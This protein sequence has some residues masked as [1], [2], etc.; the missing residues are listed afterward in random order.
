MKKG[1][2]SIVVINWNGRDDTVECVES[3]EKITRPEC[4]VIVV[5]NGSVDDSV[6]AL[7]E[8]F[9]ALLVLETGR[10]LGFAGGANFG[11]RRALNDGA[12]YVI[13]LNNDTVVDEGFA[14]EFVRAAEEHK[15]AG[16]LC[17]KVYF[18]DR[19]NTIWYA[20]AEFIT[21][22]G[23]GRHRGYNLKDDGRFDKLEETGRATGCSMMLTKE[24][25]EKAGLFDEEYFC[26]CEDMDLGMRAKKAGYKIFY[27]PA[28]RV[29]H[30]ESRAT[31]GLGSAVSL[32]YT[33]RNT[34]RCLDKNSPLPVLLRQVRFISIAGAGFLSLFTMKI[35][36]RPGVRS[37]CR[38]IM[39]YFRGRFGP[40]KA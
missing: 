3:L 12:D 22:L 19:P 21:L 33:V 38:G 11:I 14:R 40:L 25:C 36:K 18:Y 17:S 23:W 16:I 9:P 24:F 5:D 1:K 15:D 6:E 7:R 29:W 20:G 34:L 27:V 10:N 4:A 26:Y 37:V 30:K 39:D 2:V 28:S 31:G 32:Y 8:R 35:P 13:V